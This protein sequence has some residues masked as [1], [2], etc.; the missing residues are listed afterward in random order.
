M[1][2]AESERGRGGG[3][4]EREKRER[5]GGRKGGRERGSECGR[6]QYSAPLGPWRYELLLVSTVRASRLRIRD[7]MN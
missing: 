3:G 1:C 6:H 5:E 4:R 2:G 7:R